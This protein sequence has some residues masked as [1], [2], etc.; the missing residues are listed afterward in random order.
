MLPVQDMSD[1]AIT[2]EFVLSLIIGA[3]EDAEARGLL[4][5]PT[6]QSLERPL[7]L[8]KEFVGHSRRLDAGTVGE[9]YFK[10][11]YVDAVTELLSYAMN[12][13]AQ[14]STIGM[15]KSFRLALDAAQFNA[16]SWW[17]RDAP[18]LPLSPLILW[19]RSLAWYIYWF[20]EHS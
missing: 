12:C 13:A 1:E 17:I 7:A 20:A 5:H 10:P 2:P 3:P 15:P 8:I 16:C 14:N 9:P 4:V 19:S 11:G 18:S 6:K